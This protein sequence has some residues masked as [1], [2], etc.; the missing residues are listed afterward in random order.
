MRLRMFGLPPTVDVGSEQR[1]A[2]CDDSDGLVTGC[3]PTND[4][5]RGV[6]RA[7]WAWFI[8]LATVSP[9]RIV[10]QAAYAYPALV[11]LAM[12]WMY[13]IMD[14][15]FHGGCWATGHHTLLHMSMPGMAMTT[16]VV[17]ASGIM[18]H[19]STLPLVRV[20]LY[21]DGFLD[22]PLFRNAP[23]ERRLQSVSF[24]VSRRSS[25]DVDR[26]G[27]YVRCSAV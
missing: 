13:V 14:S 26:D 4:R 12:V 27:Y 1:T 2:F 5:G 11:M 19:Y 15:R 7:S 25:Y 9:R 23:K 17:P 16:A 3:S 6:L 24:A 18:D 8:L 21:R 20:L 22:I 10:E